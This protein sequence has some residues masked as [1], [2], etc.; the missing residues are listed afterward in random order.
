MY[1]EI[2]NGN[3]VVHVKI[4]GV[5]L[6]IHVFALFSLFCTYYWHQHSIPNIIFINKQKLIFDCTKKFNSYKNILVNVVVK[7]K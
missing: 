4:F 5:I 1:H 3:F 2:T 7:Y 6:Q